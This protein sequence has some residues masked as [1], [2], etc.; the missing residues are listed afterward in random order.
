MTDDPK[1]ITNQSITI[2]YQ[3]IR[4]LAFFQEQYDRLTEEIQQ[5]RVQ[6]ESSP[7][8]EPGSPRAQQR[9]EWRSWLQLQIKSKQNTR[10]NL[11][12]GIRLKGVVVE[13]LPA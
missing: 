13:N 12:K 3:T 2:D 7:P 8:L 5:V 9:E 6:L 10:D 4:D 1:Q 11:V